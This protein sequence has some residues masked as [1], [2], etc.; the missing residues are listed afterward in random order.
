MKRLVTVLL[1]TFASLTGNAAEGPRPVFIRAACDGKISSA[2]LYSLKQELRSSQKYQLIPTLDDSGRMDIVL[3]IEM[4]CTE[5]S[6]V[7]A[8]ATAYGEAKCFALNNCHATFDALSLKSVLC[9]S[10]ATAECGRARF[11]AFDDYMSNPL[12]PPLKLQ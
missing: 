1:L 8:V 2:I 11:K 4:S 10:N 3:T 7:A 5:R 9:D 6:D 12:R